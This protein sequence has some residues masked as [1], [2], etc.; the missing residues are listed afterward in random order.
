[1]VEEESRQLDLESLPHLDE[2]ALSE[3][4]AGHDLLLHRYLVL[5]VPSDLVERVKHFVR[6]TL[7]ID[8]VHK[9]IAVDCV[10]FV[11]LALD[12]GVK[13]SLVQIHYDQ[14][15]W[16]KLFWVLQFLVDLM[17]KFNFFFKLQEFFSLL[18]LAK[19]L[20]DFRNH[21]F[22]LLEVNVLFVKDLEEDR[23]SQS[24]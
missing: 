24:S 4:P 23:C 7:C 13:V 17:V 9:F 1:M 15:L 18:K 5:V 8:S 14:V 12:L 20:V 2:L 3:R 6:N 11:E 22:K 10:Y 16:L 19:E 21:N